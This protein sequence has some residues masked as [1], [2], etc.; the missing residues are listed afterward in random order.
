MLHMWPFKKPKQNRKKKFRTSAKVKKN[1]GATFN[2]HFV[3]HHWKNL[4]RVLSLKNHKLWVV[5]VVV[6]TKKSTKVHGRQN[7]FPRKK[8]ASIRVKFFNKKSCKISQLCFCH[9]DKYHVHFSKIGKFSHIFKR[10]KHLK[11]S[12]LIRIFFSTLKETIVKKV[13]SVEVSWS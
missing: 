9:S 12:V 11:L 6:D 10:K 1:P 5:S 7:L 2:Y 8:S 3:R 4:N 13:I